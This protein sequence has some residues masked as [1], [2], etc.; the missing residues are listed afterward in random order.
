M[1]D[2]QISITIPDADVKTIVGADGDPRKMIIRVAY[3]YDDRAGW[4]ATAHGPQGSRVI[5]PK[6]CG[7]ISS[8]QTV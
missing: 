3:Y 7:T 5:C 6:P 1:A 4:M 2:L 8:G